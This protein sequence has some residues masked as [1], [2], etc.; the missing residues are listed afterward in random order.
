MPTISQT[1][2]TT[3]DPRA[4]QPGPEARLRALNETELA[5]LAQKIYKLMQRDLQ[6]DRERRIRR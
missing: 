4:S 6:L 3:P 5:L 1:V 2:T